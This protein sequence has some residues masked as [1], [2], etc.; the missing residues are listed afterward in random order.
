M[1]KCIEITCVFIKLKEGKKIGIIHVEKAF[2]KF[3]PFK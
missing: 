3:S 2:A 1:R